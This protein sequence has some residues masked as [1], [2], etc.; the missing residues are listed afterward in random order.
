M[1]KFKTKSDMIQFGIMLFAIPSAIACVSGGVM[2]IVAL[3]DSRYAKADRV[4]ALSW[5][6][7]ALYLTIPNKKLADIEKQRAEFE[8]QQDQDADKLR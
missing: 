4:K 8:K 1:F 2:G 5:E 3:A 6:V 7:H